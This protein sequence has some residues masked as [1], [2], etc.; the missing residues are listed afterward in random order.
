MAA[1][2]VLSRVETNIPGV[3]VLRI[4]AD[5]A[6]TYQAKFPVGGVIFMP[7]RDNAAAD[8]WGVTYTYG[9]TL[10]TIQLIGTTTN[11]NGTLMIWKA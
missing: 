8:S 1:V 9:A 4:Q 6:E 3:E 5:D 10:L 7:E 11:V 2:E